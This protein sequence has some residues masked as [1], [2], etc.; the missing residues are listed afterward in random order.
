MEISIFAADPLTIPCDVIVE[1]VCDGDHGFLS[2]P[3][4]KVKQIG[5]QAK[6]GRE[7]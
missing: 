3:V 4:L 7:R 6:N 5:H 1:F 2:K